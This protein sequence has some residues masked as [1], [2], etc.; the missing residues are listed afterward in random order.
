M[1]DRQSENI[2]QF[3]EVMEANRDGDLTR[4]IEAEFEEDHLATLADT[5]NELL[6]EWRD[7]F[8]TV[9]EFGEQVRSASDQVRTRAEQSQAAGQEVSESIDEISGGVK[10]QDELIQ[11]MSREM[12]SLSE[13]IQ[14]VSA[15]ADEVATATDRA[16]ESGAEGREAATEAIDG[17]DDLETETEQTV[18]QIEELHEL[19]DEIE[20]VAAFI[21]DVADQ[22]NLLALNANIEAARADASGDGFAVVAEEVKSLAEATQDA[23]SEIGDSIRRIDAQAQAVVEDV[24]DTRRSVTRSCDTVR[25]VLDALEAIITD[26]E[27]IQRRT[28]EISDRTDSQTR[29]TGEV[30]EMVEDV[31][32][33]SE[34]NADEA[35]K[36]AIAA[37]EQTASLTD[38]QTSTTTLVERA[39]SLAESL[40]EITTTSRSRSRGTT[41]V[42]FWHAMSG[43]KALLL[44]DLAEEFEKQTDHDVSIDLQSK[45][46]YQDTMS[47]TIAAAEKGE[48]PAIAQIYEIGTKQAMDSGAFVPVEEHIP[49]GAVDVGSL[50]DPVL[51]YY[52]TDGTLYSMPFNSSNPILVYNADAFRR[53]GLDP[54]TAPETYEAVSETAQQLVESGAAP[55]GITF[56]N[57]SWY[58]EQWFAEQDQQLV[59]HRNGREADAT[60]AYLDSDAAVWTFEWWR[61]LERE[62]LYYN[63]GIEA[64]GEAK[65][66]FHDEEAAMLIGSTSSLAGIESGATDAGFEMGTGYFPVPDRRAGVLVGGGSLWLSESIAPRQRDAAAAFIGWLARP[67]QQ[68]RW[69]QETGYFPVHERAVTRL[70][71]D[72]WFEENPHFRTAFEQL[73]ATSDTVA[74]SGARIGPFDTVRTMIAEAY[75]GMS[76]GK[77]VDTALDDLN[78][79]VERQLAAYRRQR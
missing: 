50:L 77:P 14:E 36:I 64:R 76:D 52:R 11:E 57:Y 27:E 43:Q 58:V 32:E 54:T 18:A 31:S 71:R 74:T 16:A 39:E 22:T 59:N 44:G 5:Y 72:G 2:E 67:E 15:A 34:E 6:R 13:T 7:R 63:P 65:R 60:E 33:I 66:A 62:G 61:E 46:S 3:I 42:P 17:L 26:V 45:G 10:Q 12:H 8:G 69:H 75:D 9:E 4:E 1:D 49:D 56:A 29:L 41:I 24:H 37:Q 47:S 28:Y 30:V 40:D 25:G 55:Y 38:I 51:S 53:A 70:Q 79:K 21:D 78:T 68:A 73:R 48:P 35:E 20:D 23:T 19:I